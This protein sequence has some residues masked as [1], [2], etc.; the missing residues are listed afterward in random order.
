MQLTARLN[1]TVWVLA[2]SLFIRF[3]LSGAS[4][5]RIFLFQFLFF[6]CFCFIFFPF[7]DLHKLNHTMYLLTWY[8]NDTC[9]VTSIV[10]LY[11]T[12]IWTDWDSAHKCI[13]ALFCQSSTT[14][15]KSTGYSL[16]IEFASS[17]HHEISRDDN[18]FINVLLHRTLNWHRILLCFPL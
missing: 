5:I 1:S 3:Q 8:A 7:W 14:T 18:V 13:Y 9:T 17:R 15:P 6:S 11:A 12:H 2:V 4:V 16:S 10:L